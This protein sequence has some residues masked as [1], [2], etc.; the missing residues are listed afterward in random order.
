[1]TH[2]IKITRGDT[3]TLMVTMR[4]NNAAVPFVTGDTV[5]MTVRKSLGGDVVFTK[6]VTAFTDGAAVIKI[7]PADTASDPME[8]KYLY[9][10]QAT[11]ANGDVYTLVEIS[12]FYIGGECTYA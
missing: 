1:M 3:K 7:L 8:S 9:D 4:K 6:S 12:N 5:A 2:A 11:L 10:I